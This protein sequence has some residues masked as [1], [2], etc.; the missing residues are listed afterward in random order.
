MD[1]RVYEVGYL[2]LPTLTEEEVPA[3][4]GNLKELISSSGGE[5]ISDDAP[6]LRELAYIMEK[7]IDN[8]KKEFDRAYFGWTKFVIEPEKVDEIKKHLTTDPNYIRFLIVKT[9]RENTMAS[10]RFAGRPRQRPKRSID[11]EGAP[12][13]EINKEEIDREI[14]ALVAN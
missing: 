12:V 11:A 14:E 8:S 10:R 5:V 6:K 4:Y 3:I 1:N 9:V 2:L 13:A 7:M